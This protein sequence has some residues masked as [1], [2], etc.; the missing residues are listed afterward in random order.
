M[1]HI[2]HPAEPLSPLLPSHSTHVDSEDDFHPLPA[3]SSSSSASSSSSSSSHARAQPSQ[4]ASFRPE[5][6]STCIGEITVNGERKGVYVMVHDLNGSLINYQLDRNTFQKATDKFLELL[7]HV[8]NTDVRQAEDSGLYASLRHRKL[9]S[10]YDLNGRVTDPTGLNHW[11]TFKSILLGSFQGPLANI[12]KTRNFDRLPQ[13]QA[14]S[15]GS[16]QSSQFPRVDT[17]PNSALSLHGESTPAPLTSSSLSMNG[18]NLSATAHHAPQED[19]EPVVNAYIADLRPKAK[20]QPE[21]QPLPN[22][23]PHRTSASSTSQLYSPTAAKKPENVR[24]EEPHEKR[25]SQTNGHTDFSISP[26]SPLDSNQQSRSTSWEA[27]FSSV[28]SLPDSA[29]MPSNLMPVSLTK[30]TPASSSS[31]ASSVPFTAPVTTRSSSS[32]SS[33]APSTP[34]PAKQPDPRQAQLQNLDQ[35]SQQLQSKLSALPFT[36]PKS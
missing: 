23:Q 15:S 25:P 10:Y 31:S 19:D 14:A 34:V 7:T 13:S 28:D 29:T 20:D 2:E 27:L 36:A 21:S 11:N 12:P 33:A 16:S 24:V 1:Q 26:T 17:M 8:N 5:L 30:T 22:N 32:S 9:H 18:P 6:P 3:S 35:Q 4:D